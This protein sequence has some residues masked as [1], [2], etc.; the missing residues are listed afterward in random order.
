MLP[1]EISA[2]KA[3]KIVL[4]SA[5]GSVDADDTLALR[6]KEVEDQ[7]WKILSVNETLDASVKDMVVHTISELLRNTEAAIQKWDLLGETAKA[8][9]LREY[10]PLLELVNRASEKLHTEKEIRGAEL[11]R[12][13]KKI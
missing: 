1:K 5:F 13:G 12:P 10:I 8:N 3:L 7:L 4:V 6:K 11:T 9:R 2:R